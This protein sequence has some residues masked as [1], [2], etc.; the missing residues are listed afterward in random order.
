[1]KV[2]LMLKAPRIGFV[3]TR[4]AAG[5]GASAAREAYLWLVE[6]Q[7][8]ALPTE[9]ETIVAFAPADA[10]AEMREWLGPSL[11]YVAQCEGDLGARLDHVVREVGGPLIFLGG[12]CPYLTA[13]RLHDAAADLATH[14]VVIWPALDGGYCLLGLR[15]RLPEIFEG[16][17]WGG[18]S[19]L[20]E[21]LQRIPADLTVRI[22]DPPLE[23]VDDLSSWERALASACRQTPRESDPT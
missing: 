4:L 6:I 21:T 13:E 11:G 20:A 12:D 22:M 19:V 16:I 8:R 10:E 23:D 18:D 14:H 5:I 15:E 1:M 17:S 7:L 3:K 2:C 9:W